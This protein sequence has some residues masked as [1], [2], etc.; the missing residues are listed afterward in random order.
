[1]ELKRSK[2]ISFLTIFLMLAGSIL[3][4][5]AAGCVDYS[6]STKFVD[7]VQAEPG[8]VLTYTI[9]AA[10]SGDTS[11]STTSVTDQVSTYLEN[12]GNISEGGVYDPGR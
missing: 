3:T 7:L 4:L 1:M 9:N 12:V 6:T 11:S 8:A 10:N 5:F 2:G